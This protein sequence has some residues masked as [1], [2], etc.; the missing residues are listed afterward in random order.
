MSIDPKSAAEVL[1]RALQ[2]DRLAVLVGSHASSDT[3]DV[4][5]RSYRGLPTPEQFV[6]LCSDQYGYVKQTDSFNEVCD[7]IIAFD[8]RRELEEVLLRYY[9][10]PNDFAPTPAHKL[11]AWL[12]VSLFIT[13]NYDQFIERC[14]E[15]EGRN[16]KSLIEDEDLVRLKRR[17]TPVVKYH[18]CVTRPETMVAA[19]PD[20]DALE[21]QRKLLT[22]Y[23]SSSLAGKTLLVVGHGL[24]DYDLSRIV[25]GLCE[26]LGEYSPSIY[27]LRREGHSGKLPGLRFDAEVVTEDLTSFL[28][29]LIQ[30]TRKTG[31][32][33]PQSLLDEQWLSSSFFAALR[34]ASVLPSETQ[35]IDAFLSHLLDEISARGNVRDVLADAQAAVDLA[36]EDRPNYEALHKTWEIVTQK[37]GVITD[38]AKA[39][40]ALQE[41]QGYREITVNSFKR[42]GATLIKRNERILL[43]SQSQRVIQ[44]LQGVPPSLQKT[45]HLFICECRPKSPSPYQ[46]AIAT[47]HQLADTYYDITVCPDVVAGHLLCSHQIDRVVMGAHAIFHSGESG[48][49]SFVNTC[50]SRMMALTAV[51]HDVRVDVVGELLK[52]EELE[53]SR[54]NDRVHIHQENDLLDSA[55]GLRDLQTQR[56]RVS[57]LN[58]GYDLVPVY[59]NVH[60]HVPPNPE[61]LTS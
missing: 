38:S 27:V 8:D 49:Y 46:D 14:L 24:A 40:L 59:G 11:L 58:I 26:S 28:S 54:A 13:S 30:S 10:V 9:R 12:P 22:N 25:V 52:V 5:G 29:R 56:G 17:Q 51:N 23:I 48:Y 61:P 34:Q 32:D 47:C 35:V 16:P 36:L 31:P 53:E 50:G 43:F 21:K 33:L 4:S 37:L 45:I 57:H 41:I 2:E 55:V 60:V 1:G 15:R 19:T 42:L 3:V 18:G 7:K 20:Y 39:E 44:C 6:K